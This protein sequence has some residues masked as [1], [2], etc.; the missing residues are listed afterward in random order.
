L[1]ASPLKQPVF[2]LLRPFACAVLAAIAGLSL[3]ACKPA[4]QAQSQKAIAPKHGEEQFDFYVLALSWSPSYCAKAGTS[5]D[6]QQCRSGTGYSFVVH[7]L[8]PQYVKGYPENCPT[9]QPKTVP[10]A[11]VKRYEDLTPSA[12][13]IRHEWAKHGT[14]AG[15]T[16]HGYFEKMRAARER[17][18]IPKDFNSPSRDRKMSPETVEN[19]FARA[20]SGLP[21]DGIAITCDRRFLTGVKI[22]MT[23]ELEF[24]S[25]EEVDRNGCRLNAVLMPAPRQ[26]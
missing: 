1:Q 10:Q 19:A 8:W 26:D 2:H 25:C 21:R 4:G 9:D 5:A 18:R 23:R 24:R 22:C 13:L 20:N 7:G 17:I 16:Q 12:G 14:C 6:R 15:L 3:H 11:M